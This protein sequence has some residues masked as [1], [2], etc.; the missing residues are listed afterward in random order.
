MSAERS[1]GARF[2]RNHICSG[3]FER[4]LAQYEAYRLRHGLP[5]ALP[6]AP[7]SQRRSSRALHRRE[8]GSTEEGTVPRGHGPRSGIDAG[9]APSIWGR[10]WT[11]N[12]RQK[13]YDSVDFV[14]HY[15]FEQLSATRRDSGSIDRWVVAYARGRQIEIF[16]NF[17]VKLKVGPARDRHDFRPSA[18]LGWKRRPT[19]SM[20]AAPIVAMLR[21][22]DGQTRH[23]MWKLFLRDGNRKS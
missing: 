4:T 12:G 1:V 14:P 9:P 5:T 20:L 8:H 21:R 15:L 6:S 2:H 10:L 22:A 19:S 3:L 18:Y 7:F 23:A 17:L 13:P 11:R 16:A